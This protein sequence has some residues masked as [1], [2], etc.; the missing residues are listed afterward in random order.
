MPGLERIMIF[1]KGN[2]AARVREKEKEK[3]EVGIKGGVEFAVFMDQSMSASWGYLLV[4]YFAHLVLCMRKEK[5]A[6][7]SAVGF[8]KI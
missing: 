1:G 2:K 5:R 6:W 7:Y 8:R 3:E 4:P